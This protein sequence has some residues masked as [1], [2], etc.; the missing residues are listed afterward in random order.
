MH[1]SRI[2]RTT[3]AWLVALLWTAGAQAGGMPPN[4]VTGD[5]GPTVPAPLV[6]YQ[7]DRLNGKI[8]WLKSL[9]EAKQIAQSSNKPIFWVH[10]LGEI[11]G[12]C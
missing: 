11:D 6:K 2:V 5:A 12:D 3:A 10:V 7:V 4:I 9:D 1:N 8:N